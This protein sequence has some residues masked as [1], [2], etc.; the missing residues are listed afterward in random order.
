MIGYAL[1]ETIDWMKGMARVGGGHYP[2][3]VRFMQRLVHPG[4]MQAS[5][6][7]IDEE[8]GEANEEGKLDDVV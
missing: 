7:P 8:V 4:M 5:V 6:D 1:G 3:V 2:F